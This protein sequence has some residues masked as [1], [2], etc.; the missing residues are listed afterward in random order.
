MVLEIESQ[1]HPLSLSQK[2]IWNLEK[3]IPGTSINNICTTIR[4]EGRLDFL[5]L[6]KSIHLLL[7]SDISLRTQLTLKDEEPCQYFVPYQEETLEVYD[8]SHTGEDLSLI[9]I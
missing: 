1:L 6:Q 7:K 4:I 8:F 3:S 2:N 5:L 9:H